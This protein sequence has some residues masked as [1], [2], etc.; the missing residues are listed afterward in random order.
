MITYKKMRNILSDFRKFSEICTAKEKH[1]NFLIN[2]EKQIADLLQQLNDSHVFSDTEYKKLKPRDSRFGVTYSLRKIHKSFTGNCLPLR[3]ILSAIKTR[4]D[5][6]AQHLVPIL[7]PITTNK[8]T[9]KN[10]FEFAKEV[11]EQ[12]SGLYMA[13]L[14]V[15][16]LF[17]NIPLEETINISCDSLFSNEAKINNF[18]RNDFEKLFRMALQNNF[19]NFDGKIYKQ[20]DGVAMGS[21]L[22]SS[23]ANAFL[24]F[25]EQIWLND[26]PENFKTAYYRSYVDD[27]FVLF[28]SPDHLEKFTNYLNS[29]H[30]NIKFTYEKESNNSLPFLDI[31]ISR[32][33]NGFKTS[34]YHKPTFSG[35]YS[36]FNSF[37]YDQYKIC[38]VFTLLFRTLSI[39]SDFY[40]FHVEV[41]QLKK[42][43]RNNAFPI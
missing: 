12:D 31:L 4:S 26:C 5:N 23:L 37:V 36:K 17:T 16:S 35:V 39:A 2:L 25:H 1:L 41:C 6:I 20:T 43:L 28:R 32:S 30:K 13:S 40:R 24:S 19:F 8:F 34:V 33:E 3:L 14:D 18:N 15:E 21:P 29:K 27:I 10:S 38:L 7:E 42:I 11:I 9:I 22:G